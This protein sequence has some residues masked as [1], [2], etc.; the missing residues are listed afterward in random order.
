MIY[1][2]ISE[3]YCTK[4]AVILCACLSVILFKKGLT[5]LHIYVIIES[6]KGG[7]NMKDKI[8]E[9][10]ETVHEL[11]KLFE[12]IA[13]VLAKVALLIMALQTILQIL[14]GG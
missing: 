3:K 8:K 1:H 6:W 13:T 14:R 2:D 4:I 10:T 5:L 7:D 12:E 9:L 11:G